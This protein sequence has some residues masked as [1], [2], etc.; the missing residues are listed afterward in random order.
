LDG[1]LGMATVGA[2]PKTAT[3]SSD[4]TLGMAEAF[5]FSS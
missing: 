1:T 4:G 5:C 3:E 2:D